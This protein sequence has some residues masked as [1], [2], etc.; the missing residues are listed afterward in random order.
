MNESAFSRKPL[1]NWPRASL[2]TYLIVTILL[3]VL[4]LSGMMT[5]QIFAA[6]EGQIARINE[7]TLRSATALAQRVN[8]ELNSTAEVL[9]TLSYSESLQHDQ[10]KFFEETLRSRPLGRQNWS[11]IYLLSLAG[12]VIFDTASSGVRSYSSERPMAELWKRPIAEQVLVSHLLGGDHGDVFGTTVEVPVRVGGVPRYLL[13]AHLPISTWRNLI[14]GPDLSAQVTVSLVDGSHHMIARSRDND[15]YIGRVRPFFNQKMMN[16]RSSGSGRL[17][18]LDGTLVYSAWDT[19]TLSR[20]TVGVGVLA[21]P[22]DAARIRAIVFAV[23]TAAGCLL[24]GLLCALIITRKVTYPLKKLAANDFTA[25][26]ETIVVHE[27]SLLRDSLVAAEVQS[28]ATQERLK[29]KRDLLQKRA[30]EFETLFANIPI[31]LAFA[32]DQRCEVVTYNAAMEKLIGGTGVVSREAVHMLH[33]GQRLAPEDQPLQRAAAFGT[34]THDMELEIRADGRPPAVVI[35]SAVPLLESDGRSRGAICATVDITERKTAEARLVDAEEGLLESQR[36]V[37]LAQEAGHVGFFQYQFEKDEL[38]FTPG[39]V[40]LFELGD[41]DAHGSI[42]AWIRHIDRSDWW[43]VL[44]SLRQA[45][46]DGREIETLSYCVHLPDGNARWLTTRLQIIYVSD[47][48]PRRMVGITLDM[49]EQKKAENERTALIASEQAARMEAEK[50]NRAKDVFLAMLGHELRNPLSAITAAIEVLNQSGP[51]SE[52][53]TSARRILGHQ[54]RNLVR[55]MDDL[56]DVARVISGQVIL[57]CHRLNLA[58]KVRHVLDTLEMA[59]QPDQHHLILDLQ[60]VWIDA[61]PTRIEQIITNLAINAIKYT[62]AGGSIQIRVALTDGRA[63]LEVSN[64]GPGIPLELLP[65]IF[66][67]FVQGDRTLD[68]RDGGLGIGLSLVRS[69]VDAHEGRITIE[70]ASPGTVARVYLPATEAPPLANPSA[71]LPA[72]RRFRIVVIEDNV[73]VLEALSSLL[74]IEGHTVWTA[75]DG[76]SGLALLLNVRPDVAIVDIGLPG[77]SGLEVAK[78]SRAG[79]YPGKMVALSGYGQP[80]DIALGHAA[81]FDLYVLK[82]INFQKLHTILSSD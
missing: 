47:G 70:N 57:T 80:S 53:E 72:S 37:K 4:P 41:D 11:G 3:A 82:P 63:L 17:K 55:M 58:T 40:R 31:G 14:D 43:R 20:W 71:H 68:R 23:M 13:G 65:R 18:T 64:S 26:T 36:L 60:E 81:G 75:T 69:L 79:G 9:Q 61:D 35:V 45:F 28:Q 27:I 19:V 46:R 73:D 30:S 59:G 74:K 12:D 38:S 34:R 51:T 1:L 49:S 50:A 78:R 56:L 52:L 25:P 77:I 42:Y 5:Y 2:R 54:T 10:L 67:L 22:I 62:P 6:I 39:L 76:V 32:Q 24:L 21:E 15:V 44:R 16:G 66:D 48:W 8:Q 29:R 7:N 33:N